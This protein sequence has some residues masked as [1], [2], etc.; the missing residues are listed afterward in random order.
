MHETITLSVLAERLEASPAYK[1]ADPFYR[2]RLSHDWYRRVSCF[3]FDP[4]C[5]TCQGTGLK[6]YPNYDCQVCGGSGLIW[7][8]YS[9]CEQQCPK[10]CPEQ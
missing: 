9:D 1:N 2:A 3:T 8:R 10:G 4:P 7:D 6:P 5:S